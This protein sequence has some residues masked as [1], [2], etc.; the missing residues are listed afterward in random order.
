MSEWGNPA[1]VISCH[2]PVEY[3]DR[4][5]RT[6]GIETS[7]YPQEQKSKEIPLVAASERGIAQTVALRC[8][9]VVGPAIWDGEVLVEQSGKAG[10]RG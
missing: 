7:Q 5:R 9:G 4:G 2:P 8:N 10:H 1:G 6:G 3:I